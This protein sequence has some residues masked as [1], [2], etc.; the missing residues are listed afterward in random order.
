MHD[1]NRH[2]QKRR[3]RLQVAA[4]VASIVAFALLVAVLMAPTA[5]AQFPLIIFDEPATFGQCLSDADCNIYAIEDPGIVD[6]NLR[7]EATTSR[8]TVDPAESLIPQ[9]ETPCPDIVLTRTVYGSM[10]RCTDAAGRQDGAV[11]INLISTTFPMR[12]FTGVLRLYL[13]ASPVGPTGPAF[14]ST[15]FVQEMYVSFDCADYFFRDVCPNAPNLVP[16]A[17]YAIKY[18]DH[19]GCAALVTFDVPWVSTAGGLPLVAPGSGTWAA[20]DRLSVLPGENPIFQTADAR[21]AR[22]SLDAVAWEADFKFRLGASNRVPFGQVM[23]MQGEVLATVVGS[24]L[25]LGANPG[26]QFPP[27][28]AAAYADVLGPTLVSGRALIQLGIGYVAQ[29]APTPT[30]RTDECGR[31]FGYLRAPWVLDLSNPAAMQPIPGF[32]AAGMFV[33]LQD[34]FFNTWLINGTDPFPAVDFSQNPAV[35]VVHAGVM[36]APDVPA[37]ALCANSTVP[38]AHVSLDYTAWEFNSN[39]NP[40]TVVLARVVATSTNM[41]LQPL[42]PPQETPNV[43]TTADFFVTEPGFY[44]AV[45]RMNLLDGLGFRAILRTCFQIGKAAATL[46]QVR[47]YYPPTAGAPYTFLGYTGIGTG[48]EVRTEF[49]VGVPPL[50]VVP[51]DIMPRIR[52][53]K[54]SN[55]TREQELLVFFEGTQFD[56]FMDD[57]GFLDLDVF[58]APPIVGTNHTVF[59]ADANPYNGAAQ[60]HELVRETG[61]RVPNEVAMVKLQF[62][63]GA[64]KTVQYQC[65]KAVTIKGL[66][67]PALKTRIVVD[68]AI[69]PN[70]LSLMTAHTIGG[71]AFLFDNPIFTG[72][73]A[74]TVFQTPASYFVE[75][76]NTATGVT[77]L[78]GLNKVRFP[79]P[80]NDLIRL[81]VYDN[82]G[83]FASDFAL[84]TTSVMAD[85]TFVS[86]LPQ[87]PICV[88]GTQLVQIDYVIGGLVVP[89]RTIAYWQPLDVLALELYNPNVPFFDLPEECPLLGTM[90]AHDVFLLCQA[91]GAPGFNTTM[92]APCDNL[93]LARPEVAGASLVTDEDDAFWEVVV[94]V[95]TDVF[96]NV[97]GRYVYCRSANSTSARVPDPIALIFT[98]LRRVRIQQGITTVPCAGDTC[99]AVRVGR[100]VEAFYR[101][102]FEHLVGFTA[103]PPLESVPNA[104]ATPAITGDDIFVRLGE[105]YVFT[106][107]FDDVLCPVEIVVTFLP[108]GPLLNLARTTRASCDSPTGSAVF[109]A[110]YNDPDELFGGSAREVCM[111][112]PDRDVFPP[113]VSAEQE[114]FDFSLPVNAERPTMLPFQP[115]FIEAS[116]FEHVRGGL[117]RLIVYDKCAAG[118]GCV[119]DCTSLISNQDTFALTDPALQFHIF[120][121]NVTNFEDPAGGIVID[122]TNFTEAL[123]FGDTYTFRFSV[124]DDRGDGGLGFPPYQWTF[125]EPVTGAVLFE[126]RTC[127]FGGVEDMI[128]DVVGNFRVHLFDVEGIEVET[129]PE[130]GL[131]FSGNYTLAVRSCTSGCIELFQTFIDIVQPIGITLS[132]VPSQCASTPGGLLAQIVGGAPF[133]PGE[134]PNDFYSYPGSSVVRTN[135]YIQEWA[136]PLSPNNLTQT[137]LPIQAIPG[138]YTLVAT[139]RNTCKANATIEVTSAPP[140][141]A[142]IIGVEAV[143][144]TSTTANISIRITGGV[145]PYR[146]IQNLTI[147]GAGQDLSFEFVSSFD[148]NATFHVIDAVGCIS[149]PLSFIPPP[150]ES[151]NLTI[152][153]TPSCANTATGRV[154]VTSDD[155]GASGGITCMY[156]TD[157]ADIPGLQTCVLDNIPGGTTVRVFARNIIGCLATAIVE[158]PARSP[159]VVMET[160]RSTNG[161]FGSGNCTDVITLHAMGGDF[162]P[163]YQ[164]A[165]VDDPTNATLVYNGTLDI[166]ITGVCR[167]VN[168][169]VLVRDGDGGCPTMVVSADPEFGFGAGGGGE[170]PVGLPPPGSGG[171]PVFGGSGGGGD[172]EGSK[173]TIAAEAGGIVGAMLFVVLI[174][175]VV[176]VAAGRIPSD[177]TDPLRALPQQP[178]AREPYAMPS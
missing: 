85:T 83:S 43:E 170:F 56:I 14:A 48:T 33:R 138:N 70:E 52:L 65:A 88:N 6:D 109:F 168:Y 77:Q 129:G 44:C 128:N 66:A 94:W 17:T 84:A 104:V 7:C 114:F 96:D 39:F 23:N 8:C 41:V 64:N 100:F 5:S 126:S 31:A 25:W 135:Q 139:D 59:I 34:V 177:D 113:T 74:S 142:E 110:S 47:S 53:C 21:L 20:G 172:G 159:I 163:P 27:F 46:T 18:F 40:A 73:L 32:V 82:A 86:F 156:Q 116:R 175:A 35:R 45:M 150:A 12:A 81:N 69:C 15:A 141:V 137:I 99:F 176:I 54:S 178:F 149:Q 102:R 90:S 87:Q 117:H 174:V 136:T 166:A 122:R 63:G 22:L 131:R 67:A 144:E 75:W 165:L 167:S 71:F 98:D 151:F 123:C 160:S 19:T 158:V 153:V 173:N 80:G 24:A 37:P 124:F 143:C 55:D 103:E 101:D 111:F 127:Q 76:I 57:M 16:G 62:V 130:F 162:A 28:A 120:E 105:T 60:R 68:E 106:A 30:V 50:L 171:D 91:P 51:N 72:V 132:A 140:L 146:T 157:G 42:V 115:D 26:A 29:G 121:F 97:T 118:V 89:G 134:L 107:F 154:A 11:H 61:A 148:Q 133:R 38:G 125:H 79:A 78:S 152:D 147:V 155:P 108:R 161:T 2:F 145:P 10:G 1:H 92:C 93:P 169:V 4:A 9:F 3:R 119:G 95:P 164:V 13:L 112:W 58:Y 36:P 49:I